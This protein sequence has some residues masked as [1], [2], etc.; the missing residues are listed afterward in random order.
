MKKLFSDNVWLGLLWGAVITILGFLAF[1]FFWSMAKEI[2]MK[3]FVDYIFLGSEFYQ[4]NIVTIS[5]LPNVIL[6]YL[7]MRRNRF[8]FCAGL[9]VILVVTVIAATLL[10]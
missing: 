5:A 7:M 1:G 3:Q 8:R 4:S 10:Y 6:F 2:T 9:L